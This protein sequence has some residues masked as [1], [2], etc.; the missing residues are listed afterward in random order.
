MFNNLY[1][2]ALMIRGVPEES[3]NKVSIAG[4][5][6]DS[7]REKI[8][9]GMFSLVKSSLFPTVSAGNGKN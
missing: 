8:L 6:M 5:W 1:F 3:G 2:I 9:N 7:A 4:W